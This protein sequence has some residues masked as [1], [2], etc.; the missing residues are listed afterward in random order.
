MKERPFFI[1][2]HGVDGTGKTKTADTTASQ[3]L[4]MGI[5]AIN[6]DRYERDLVNPHSVDRARILL[7]ES[8]SSQLAHYLKS[9]MFHS[10]NIQELLRKGY[11][12]VKSR[13]VDDVLAHHAHLGVEN[14]AEMEHLFPIVQPDLRVILTLDEVMRR[15]RLN[16]RGAFDNRDREEKVVGSR[17]DFFEKYLLQKNADLIRIGKAIRIDTGELNPQQVAR[18]IIDFLLN[19]RGEDCE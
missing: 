7:E 18:R 2:I 19:I 16:R 9:T 14:V 8:P 13:Y 4:D 3:L 15:E 17:L 6:Y 5:K 12:V 11:S 1:A 10:D